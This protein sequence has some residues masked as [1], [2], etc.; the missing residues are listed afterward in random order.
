MTY[1]HL[2]KEKMGVFIGSWPIHSVAFEVV[3]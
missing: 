3:M 1:V 2:E